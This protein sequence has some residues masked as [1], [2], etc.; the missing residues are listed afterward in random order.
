[1]SRAWKA[2][3]HWLGTPFRAVSNSFQFLV[4]L[5]QQQLK[6]VLTLAMIGGMV[7]LTGVN[8]WYTYR[9]EAAV[10]QG[11]EYHSFFEL[12]QEQL[13]FNSGLIGWFALIMGL[14]V[15]GADYFHAK[16][17]NKEFGAGKGSAPTPPAP[18]APV[19]PPKPPSA[20]KP[21]EPD[22]DMFPESK[23]E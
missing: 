20:A 4:D 5:T 13:R 2:V 21:P 6:S 8:I 3:M 15:F 7:A 16:W 19:E 23:P 22:P 18:A 1:M 12:L 9:A 11:P 17:G 14:I 10:G